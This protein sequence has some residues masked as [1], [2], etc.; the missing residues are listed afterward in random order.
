MLDQRASGILLHP[1]SLPS[2]YGIGD[3]GGS[4]YRFVDF[5]QQSGQRVWQI[6]PLGPA[7]AGN[8]PYLAYSALAG[9]PLLISPEILHGEGLLTE[10][11]LAEVKQVFPKKIPP[12]SVLTR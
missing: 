4:A 7:G 9:N 5:L 11:E 6:L 12:M 1:T 3:L 10:G 2:P 8:S